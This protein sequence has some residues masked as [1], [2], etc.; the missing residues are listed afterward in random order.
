[1]NY[2]SQ[3]AEMIHQHAEDLFEGGFIDKKTMVEFDRSCL[4]PIKP[5]S[6][7]EIRQIRQ[8]E[9]FSQSV[10]AQYLNV[11]KN[12]VSDWERGVKKPSNTALK[13]LTLVQYKGIEAIA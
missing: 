3:I 12:L 4:T 2:R 6:A 5:L 10:F 9:N 1:M 11:S 7:D 8:K 13:L